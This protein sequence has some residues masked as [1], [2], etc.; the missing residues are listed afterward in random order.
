[1]Q[2]ADD[3]FG[4]IGYEVAKTEVR[5]AYV[6]RVEPPPPPPPPAPTCSLSLSPASITQGGKASLSFQSVNAKRGVID[7]GVGSV[8]QA[9]VATVSPSQTTTFIG[10]FEGAGGTATCRATLKV[11]PPPIPK[12]E[13][14]V[15]KAYPDRITTGQG[16]TLSWT[17]K[18]ATSV[19]IDNEVGQTNG[20][21]ITVSP[22]TS[23][24]YTLTA[25]N[26]SGDTNATA[27]VRVDEPS[28]LVLP[29]DRCGKIDVVK[30]GRKRTVTGFVGRIDDLDWVKA[31]AKGADVDV[32][33][34][35][36]PQC[37]ALMTIDQPLSRA[38]ADG[39]EVSIRKPDGLALKEGD[40]LLF[41]VET[42]SYP[43]YIHA[44][45]IQA[46][47]SVVNLTKLSN[48]FLAPLKPR[49]H[50]VFGSG[51]EWGRF[52]VSAPYGREMLIVLAGKQPIF[53]EAR[54]EQETEREFLT[55]VRKALLS[56]DQSAADA[57]LAAN[58]DTV[59]TAEK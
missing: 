4:W 23:T 19:R 1:M 6:M 27:T 30:R 28:P 3:G 41:E 48:G 57:E 31:N 2:W 11:F 14:V 9:G 55:A 46:D 10:T 13:V 37:E 25:S 15:F 22:E 8:G 43:S 7:N 12:P 17:V 45:Y 18:G 47:G 54:P 35:P 39:L 50:L 29:S 38:T 5:V 56:R 16:S 33:V 32:E 49:S 24:T 51:D 44:A 58:Y 52:R 53:S 26:V 36:W 21:A 59:V 34:R 20:G 40:Q 42:P